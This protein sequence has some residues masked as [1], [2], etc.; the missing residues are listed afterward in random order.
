MRLRH[1]IF[2][3]AMVLAAGCDT[4]EQ[5]ADGQALSINKEPV[6]LL[7]DGGFIDLPSRIMAPGKIRVEITG[8]TRNGSLKDLGAGLLQ[9]APRKGA[10]HDSFGFRVFNSSN[11]VLAEDTIG[12]IIPPDTTDLPCANSIYTRNDT[13]YNVTGV[14]IIDVLANDYSCAPYLH[15]GIFGQPSYGTATLLDNKVRYTPGPSFTGY[16]SIVYR[17]NVV[18]GQPDF[19]YAYGVVYIRKTSASNCVPVANNDLFYKPL[20][21]T[22]TI[23]LDVLANDVLCDSTNT[24]TVPVETGPRRGFA[25]ADNVAKKIWYRNTIGSNAND[26]LRYQLCSPAGC[27]TARVIIVRQ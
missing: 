25:T 3:L 15:V 1:A 23:A 5:D 26:T 11:R 6:Y 27:S 2:G 7:A 17:A 20:N 19:P 24:I 12:I 10:A 16:D 21:D 14:T 22:S 9:Y 8:S 18:T 13:V 4:M